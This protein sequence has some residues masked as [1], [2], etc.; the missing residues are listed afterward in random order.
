[1]RRKEHAV[2]LHTDMAGEFAH[3]YDT[4][5][6]N[7]Y[8]NTFT[9]GRK[10]IEELLDLVVEGVP[11]GARVLDAGCG[12]GFTLHKLADRGF[13]V[14]GI[15]PSEGM[16]VQ[17]RS[18]YPDIPIIGGDIEHLPFPSG[19]FDLVVS[20]EVL[21]YL[22]VP[23]KS[24]SELARV[25]RPGGIAFVTATPRYALNGYALVSAV[26]S[27][28]AVPTFTKVETSFMTTR[29]AQQALRL[30]GFRQGEIHGRFIGPWH[31]LGRIAPRSV[32]PL[33]RRFE[34]WDDKWSDRDLTR[35]LANHLVLIG[36]R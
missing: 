18:L 12:T 14:V 1:V 24:L 11:T 29:S 2:E 22:A 25:L 30:A 6:D 19:T 3:R 31:V 34:P 13:D 27:R 23:D 15:E 33:L 21:R 17:A 10:K 20:I 7:P 26:T 8:A 16:R 28:V 9:Y 4:L 36:R 5:V 35:D 32:P